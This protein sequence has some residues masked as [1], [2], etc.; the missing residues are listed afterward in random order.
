MAAG[1]RRI[2]FAAAAIYWA[3]DWILVSP[4]VGGYFGEYP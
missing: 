4:I 1:R 3:W 2:I